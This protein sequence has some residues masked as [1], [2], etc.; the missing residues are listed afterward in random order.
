MAMTPPDPPGPAPS[1]RGGR[2]RTTT[3]LLGVIAV[4]LA[5]I[6]GGILFLITQDDD[7]PPAEPTAAAST[8]T[9]EDDASPAP[10]ASVS[11]TPTE[12]A[13]QVSY[14]PVRTDDPEFSLTIESITSGEN[15]VVIGFALTF[16]G[17]SCH[18]FVY[19]DKQFARAYLV[20]DATNQKFEVVTDANGNKLVSQT[21]GDTPCEAGET[22]GFTIQFTAPMPGSSV[23]VVAP[24]AQPIPGVQ[25]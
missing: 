8:E 6:A 21:L 7:S 2:D 22:F 19:T 4:L 14:G 12:P 16:E 10:E 9:S 24:F 3:F 23:T 25:L 18:T 1:K 20:D 11:P 17:D 5:V 13:E 15:S